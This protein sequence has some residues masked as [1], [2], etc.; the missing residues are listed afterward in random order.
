MFVLNWDI[1]IAR[2]PEVYCAT[3]S[4]ATGLYFCPVAQCGGQSGTRFNLRHHF[5]MQHPKDLVC[6]LIEGSQPLLKCEHC[7]LQ[8]PVEDLN[9]SHHRTVLF[10]RGWER[11]RQHAAAVRSQEALGRSFTAYGE[12]LVRVEVFKY[13]GQLIAYDDA[14]IQAMQSNLRNTGV[15]V[16]NFACATG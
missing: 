14:D 10:Q 8:M 3:E 16:S 1:I 2:A 11:K 15:L 5:L 13:L 7:G 4:P 12:D 9:G 6:I